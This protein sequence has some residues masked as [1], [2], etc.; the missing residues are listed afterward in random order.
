MRK[1]NRP[2]A[3]EYGGGRVPMYYRQNFQSVFE[4]P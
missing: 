1:M 2:T 4:K 3:S